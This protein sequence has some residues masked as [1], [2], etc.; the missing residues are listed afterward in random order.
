M[1]VSNL[2]RLLTKLLIINVYMLFLGRKSHGC[3]MKKYSQIVHWK[4]LLQC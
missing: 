2:V 1:L 3:I 4:I